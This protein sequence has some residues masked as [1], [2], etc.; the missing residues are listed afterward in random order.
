MVIPYQDVTDFSW[1]NTQEWSSWYI[2]LSKKLPNCFPKWMYHFICMSFTSFMFSPTLSMVNYFNFSHSKSK[3]C[4]IPPWKRLYM[5]IFNFHSQVYPR[6]FNV[7][8]PNNEALLMF[9]SQGDKLQKVPSEYPQFYS[10]TK[11]YNK[12]KS[13]FLCHLIL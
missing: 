10:D 12:K 2:W 6:T 8:Y 5:N 1:V 7:I 13:K 9:S 4:L 3:P 11:T